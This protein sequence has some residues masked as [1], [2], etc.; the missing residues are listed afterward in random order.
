VLENEEV[1]MKHLMLGAMFL[2]GCGLGDVATTAAVSGAAK[3]R[4]AQQAEQTKQQVMERL[5]QASQQAADRNKA[6]ESQ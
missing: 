1:V 3:A 5:D 2:A 6:A 4:E